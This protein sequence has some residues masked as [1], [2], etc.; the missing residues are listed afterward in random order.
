MIRPYLSSF[1]LLLVLGGLGTA[2]D[3]PDAPSATVASSQKRQNKHHFEGAAP[4]GRRPWL[5][6]HILLMDSTTANSTYWASTLTLFGTTIVNVE[7]T[8]RC[9]AERTCLTMIDPG[10]TRGQMYLYTMPTDIAISYLTY[11]LKGK[12]HWWWVPQAAVSG[13]NLFSAGRSYGR[14]NHR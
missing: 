12:T 13:A 11:K 8:S 3:L 6:S 5:A 2:Q 14:I 1:M 7:T 9:A 4:A 10:A